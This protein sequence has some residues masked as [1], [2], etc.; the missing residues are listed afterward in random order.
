MQIG[1]FTK[2]LILYNQM[3]G[4]IV[5]S[6]H[7]SGSLWKV[8][9]GI[10]GVSSGTWSWACVRIWTTKL[11]KTPSVCSATCSSVSGERGSVSSSFSLSRGVLG[12]SPGSSGLFGSALAIKNCLTWSVWLTGSL[13]NHTCLLPPEIATAKPP[14]SSYIIV[15]TMFHRGDVEPGH[16]MQSYTTQVAGWHRPQTTVL[17]L[18]DSAS[19]KLTVAAVA[20][21]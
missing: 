18:N 9:S 7:P 6:T 5:T 19:P 3:W 13:P 12:G 14:L 1:P 21:D 4:R 17:F 11:L 15:L 10:S 2:C 20:P 8:N 16:P